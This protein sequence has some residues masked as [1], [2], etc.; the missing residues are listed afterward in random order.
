MGQYFS[1][2]EEMYRIFGA[3]YDR[4]K[5]DEEV[6]PKLAKANLIVRFN[7]T[8]PE[9]S[10]TINAKDKPADEKAFLDYRFDDNEQTPDVTMTQTA[11]FSHRFW[12]GRENAIMAIATRKIKAEGNVAAA[13]ALLPA[14]RPVFRLYPKV[15]KDIGR[16]E[17]I[18]K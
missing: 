10:V 9:G 3:L 12:H 15:L 17:L 8:D 14:I 5:Y 16:E 7:Y 4:V 2:T 6:G 13:L 18:V 11:D 1:S